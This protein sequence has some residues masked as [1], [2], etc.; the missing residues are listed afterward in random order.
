MLHSAAPA[1]WDLQPIVARLWAVPVMPVL[2]IGIAVTRQARPA[3][4]KTGSAEFGMGY[5]AAG[6]P[7][8][9]TGTL[10]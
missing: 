5:E 10:M 8:R 4:G 9:A 7:A 6:V 1:S 3:V 2:A